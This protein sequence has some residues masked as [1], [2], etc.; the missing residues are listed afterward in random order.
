MY[1]YQ[2]KTMTTQDPLADILKNLTSSV[3]D[4]NKRYNE[5][6]LEKAQHDARKARAEA[7]ISETLLAYY[8]KTLAEAE[9]AKHFPPIKG[10]FTS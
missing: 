3:D 4:F 5:V 2:K 1:P 6:L 7:D 10:P 8:K 9:S